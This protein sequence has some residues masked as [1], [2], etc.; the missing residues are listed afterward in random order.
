MNHL[1]GWPDR[2]PAELGPYS[3]L[4]P[5]LLRR[6]DLRRAGLPPP[7]RQGHV[8]RCLHAGVALQFSRPLCSITQS[9]S[10][11]IPARATA[12]NTRPHNV[13][14]CLGEDKWCSIA[15]FNDKEWQNLCKVIGKPEL[16]TDNKFAT[17]TARKSNEN[18]LDKIIGEW[19]AKHTSKT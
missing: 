12:S 16:A 7:H 4:S 2:E 13:Y 14:P 3:I 9:T 1:T 19:T 18:E 17:L 15:V 11:S 6:A 5:A 10:V 8:H